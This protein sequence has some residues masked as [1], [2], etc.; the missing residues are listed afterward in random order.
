MHSSKNITYVI[1]VQNFN[2]IIQIMS[3]FYSN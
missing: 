3:K 1:S 2:V